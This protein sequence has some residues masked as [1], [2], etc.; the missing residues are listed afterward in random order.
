ML[1]AMLAGRLPEFTLE[2]AIE[3]R[4]RLV[5]DFGGDFRDAP[6]RIFER[7]RGQLKPPARQVCHGRLG[8]ISGKALHQGGSG[9]A[10][11]A[12]Q[13]RD[14]PGMAN[15][16]MKQSEAFPHDR[17]A[18]SRQPPHLLFWQV[19]N[20]APQGVDEQSLGEFRKHGCAADPSRSCFFDQV[21]DRIFKPLPGAIRPDIDLKDGRQSVQNRP[22]QEGS[23]AMY[24]QTYRAVSPPPPVCSGL[25]SCDLTLA[26]IV[27]VRDVAVTT[28]PLV[29]RCGS[30][31]GRTTTSPGPSS[32]DCPSA[33]CTNASPSITKW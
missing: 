7:P 33:N 10:H 26:R 5:S 16:A 31:W 25:K 20:V 22:A 18:R 30:P 11:L 3:G 12:C 23:Q 13:I 29:I 4:L 21:Q 15:A 6:G 14:G 2:R 27:E 32:T 19:G 24:P 8:E 9:N 17:I 28:L 1:A